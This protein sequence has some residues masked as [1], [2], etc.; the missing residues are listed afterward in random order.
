[1]QRLFLPILH[2]LILLSGLL[3]KLPNLKL[4]VGHWGEMLPYY[5]KRTSGALN[6]KLTGLKHD[7]LYYFQHH[8]YTNPSG[9]FDQEEFEFCL[10]VLPKENILWAQDFPYLAHTGHQVHTF[11][12]TAEIES[13]LKEDVAFRNA[14]KLF[15]L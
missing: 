7:L 11:L 4:I 1:M 9:M 8:I 10:K 13:Q 12:E 5:L 15:K 14:E 2:L 3:D 6:P